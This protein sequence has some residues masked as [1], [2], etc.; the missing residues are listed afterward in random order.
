MRAWCEKSQFGAGSDSNFAERDREL[1]NPSN[2]TQGS[3]PVVRTWNRLRSFKSDIGSARAG[4]K[5]R[6]GHCMLANRY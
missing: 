1:W 2:A 3:Q 5:C 4:I 6:L